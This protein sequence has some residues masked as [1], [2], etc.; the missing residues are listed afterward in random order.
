MTAVV[1]Q[2]PP[3]V[4]DGHHVAYQRDDA[5][6]QYAC[7]VYTTGEGRSPVLASVK[8]ASVENCTPLE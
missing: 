3:S 4:L 5:K 2:Y 8:Q 6:A 1:V 7:F